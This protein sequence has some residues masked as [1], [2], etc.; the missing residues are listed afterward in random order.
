[1]DANLNLNFKFCGLTSLFENVKKASLTVFI[2]II[3]KKILVEKKN[4]AWTLSKDE[5]RGSIAGAA[6]VVSVTR[7]TLANNDTDSIASVI[8]ADLFA[9]GQT[10]YG[11]S[12]LEV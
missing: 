4:F 6:M 3:K 10:V 7:E 11:P 12:S 8:M 2:I 1:L 9:Y 5:F